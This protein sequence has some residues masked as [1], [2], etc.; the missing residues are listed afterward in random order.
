[1][2]YVDDIGLTSSDLK[3]I[4]HVKSNLKNNLDMIDLGYLHYFLGLQVFQS[5]EGI[6]LLIL[7]ILVTFFSTLTWNIVNQPLFPFKLESSYPSHVL[8]LK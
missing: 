3:L 6:T 7:S 1:M 8:L 5:K 4:N 2:L